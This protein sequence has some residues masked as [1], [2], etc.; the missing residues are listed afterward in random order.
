[1]GTRISPRTTHLCPHNPP[2]GLARRP[3]PTERVT[4][5]CAARP[6]SS[7]RLMRITI[8][9]GTSTGQCSESVHRASDCRRPSVQ[10]MGVDHGRFQ[11]S[12][13]QELLDGADIVAVFQEV[14][15]KR[16]PKGVAG[17]PLGEPCPH[18]RFSHG[19][20]KQR[21]VCMMTSLFSG[22]A[23]LPPF[24]L[25]EH[26]PPALPRNAFTNLMRTSSMCPH[27]EETSSCRRVRGSI[28][29]TRD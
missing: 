22:S 25:R 13:T 17:R 26:P 2:A 20:L 23:V 28:S 16:M 7:R 9:A 15:R 12:M 5:T 18:H 10:N 1:M 11:I 3:P 27:H 29:R 4:V 24:L 21:L 19:F 14:R 6:V 8:T